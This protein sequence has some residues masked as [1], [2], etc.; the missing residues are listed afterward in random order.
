MGRREGRRLNYQLFEMSVN[1]G[2]SSQ[3]AGEGEP[4]FTNISHISG[5]GRYDTATMLGRA[6][7]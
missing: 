6:S 5:G 3:M 7:L 4:K 2:G 1:T